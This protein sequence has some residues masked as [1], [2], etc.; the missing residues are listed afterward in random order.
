MFIEKR[1]TYKMDL[2]KYKAYYNDPE[3]MQGFLSQIV[4]IRTGTDEDFK[5]KLMMKGK[6]EFYSFQPSF[7]AILKS[8][9]FGRNF[10]N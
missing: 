1:F 5:L 2:E 8:F 4:Y 3:E 6:V 7:W 10:F 9:N